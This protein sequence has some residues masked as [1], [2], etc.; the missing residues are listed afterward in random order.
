MNNGDTC[1]LPGGP[2]VNV[3]EPIRGSC[4]TSAWVTVLAA[5]KGPDAE[6][7]KVTLALMPAR[8]IPRSVR[9]GL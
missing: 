8:R 3:C 4:H 9:Q 5:A 7:P 6:H 1:N 2:G